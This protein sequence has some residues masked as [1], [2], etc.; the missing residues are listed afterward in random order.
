MP[1]K[2]LSRSS[3][4]R[5]SWKP[6]T[7]IDIPVSEARDAQAQ[8][9]AA[10]QMHPIPE[11]SNPMANQVTKFGSGT[12]LHEALLVTAEEGT[13]EAIV[14]IVKKGVDVNASG[15]QHGHALCTAAFN[16]RKEIVKVLIEQGAM[17]NLPANNRDGYALHA[18]AGEGHIDVVKVLLSKGAKV[19]AQ[20]GQFR[21][22]LTAGKHTMITIVYVDI[23]NPGGSGV[24]WKHTDHQASA[25][26]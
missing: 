15:G 24:Q 6:D 22:P 25:R 1:P 26:S 13:P 10:S 11:H 21:F 16:G 9:T 20:G 19:Q 8:Y 14:R 5:D 2:T 3:T 4:F 18:A 7:K 23:L 17:V 12:D